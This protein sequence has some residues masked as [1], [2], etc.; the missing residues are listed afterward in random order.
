M[1]G[2]EFAVDAIP[3]P[4]DEPP[5]GSLPYSPSQGIPLQERHFDPQR[6]QQ[7][8]SAAGE[9]EGGRDDESSAE[10]SP[11]ALTEDVDSADEDLPPAGALNQQE[12]EVG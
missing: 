7:D 5:V 1:G 10:A 12:I 3:Q 4:E 9:L 11:D 6:M 8:A 2:G